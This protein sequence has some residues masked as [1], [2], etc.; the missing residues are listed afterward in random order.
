MHGHHQ[1]GG[2][3]VVVRRDAHTMAKAAQDARPARRGN[4]VAG[5]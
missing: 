2:S 5:A 1:I 4:A 3:A